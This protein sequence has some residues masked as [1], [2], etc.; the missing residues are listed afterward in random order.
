MKMHILQRFIKTTP[1]LT[2]SRLNADVLP[3]FSLGPTSFPKLTYTLLLSTSL[4]THTYRSSACAIKAWRAISSDIPGYL[5]I[6][7]A[8]SEFSSQKTRLIL[9]SDVYASSGITS[10]SNERF[11]APRF[12]AKMI[13]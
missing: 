9:I 8:H 7:G 11:Y 5:G 2:L 1:A 10:A 12:L 3:V 13:D 6:F 4:A